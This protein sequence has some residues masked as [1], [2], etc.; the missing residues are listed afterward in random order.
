[1]ENSWWQ[2]QDYDGIVVITFEGLLCDFYPATSDEFNSMK[3]TNV[4]N[5]QELCPS[6]MI[7]LLPFLFILSVSLKNT[8][9]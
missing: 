3:S 9:Y 4:L 2:D 8:P 1:M 7:E 5:T 6:G